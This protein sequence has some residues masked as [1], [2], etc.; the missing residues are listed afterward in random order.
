MTSLGIDDDKEADDVLKFCH[1]IGHL[2]YHQGCEL[3]VLKPQFLNSIVSNIITVIDS[4]KMEGDLAKYWRDLKDKGVLSIELIKAV[5]KEQ[6]GHRDQLDNIIDMMIKF[7]LICEIPEKPDGRRQFFVPCRSSPMLHE[8]E[9][10]DK[11]HTVEFTIDFHHF[12]PDGFLHRFYVRMARWSMQNKKSI[13]PTFHCRQMVFYIDSR[14]RVVMT[15]EINIKECHQIKVEIYA[16][17][18]VGA[19]ATVNLDGKIIEDLHGT[20]EDLKKR[21]AGRIE[22]SVGI[23]CP[24]CSKHGDKELIRIRDILTD[25]DEYASCDDGCPSIYV[26]D[27]LRAFNKG[28]TK[29]SL[30]KTKPPQGASAAAGEVSS[31]PKAREV[32]NA[33]LNTLAR[34]IPSYAYNTFSEKL[35][36]EHTQARNILDKYSSDYEKSTRECIAKWMDRSTRSV[37][38]LHDVL[39]ETELGGLIVHCN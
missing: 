26:G 29:T 23:V 25:Q 18:P 36:I 31:T 30:E 14:H 6:K 22:Y 34:Y 15:N 13:K 35:G 16:T 12:L 9:S 4:E 27:I 21:W 38:D 28:T 8:K 1:D 3:I 17:V 24:N 5:W 33:M 11:G 10:H 32:D 7:D 20:L 2:I 37:T 19:P 39:R